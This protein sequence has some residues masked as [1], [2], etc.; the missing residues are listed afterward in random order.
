MSE[1][2]VTLIPG[3]GLGPEL[4][5]ITIKVINAAGVSIKWDTYITG[6]QAIAEGKDPLP[7]EAVESIRNNRVAFKGRI[8]TPISR[9]YESPNVRLRKALD[10][11][12]SVRP[13][14]SIPGLP[15]R[16]PDLDLVIVRENTEDV[17]AG[18]EHELVP[19]VVES[20]KVVTENACTRIA[21]FA[22]DY[23]TREKRKKITLIHKGNILKLSDGL[24]I[25]CVRQVAG[26][27]PDIE[28]EEL[29][30]DN[31]C[32]QLVLNPYRFDVLLTGNLYGDIISDLCAGLGGGL[33]LAAGINVGKEITV[34]ESI[35]G[36]APAIEGRDLANPLPFLI[37]AIYMLRSFKEEEAADRIFQGI[38]TVLEEGKVLTPDLG[39]SAS[40][41]RMMEEIIAK[42]TSGL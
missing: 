20:L 42:M 17:Y 29:I 39:G 13:V 37:P 28:F 21:S 33:G 36:N 31:A 11:F 5:E 15:S 40:T 7:A 26:Q 23:A 32:M 24:F 1:H 12:A 8:F 30:A 10:L 27:Y 6:K 4:S 14:R 9:G 34:F 22:F 35:H 19:G 16:Y 25:E 18:I 2:K 41:T 3:D 38:T